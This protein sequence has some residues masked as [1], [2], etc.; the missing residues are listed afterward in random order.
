MKKALILIS[1]SFVLA[2]LIGGCGGGGGGGG[3]ETTPT[4]TPTGTTT[5]GGSPP[6]NEW[7]TIP[8]GDFIMGSG[9]AELPKHTVTLSEYKIQK[10]EVTNAQ[11]AACVAATACTAPA[12]ADS[13]T[14]PPSYTLTP[15]YGNATYNNYPVIFVNWTQ[16]GEYCAWVGGRLPTEAEWEKAARGPTPAEPIYPWGDGAADCTLANYYRGVSGCVGDTSEVGSHPTGVSYYGAMDMAGNVYEWVNDWYDATYYT[17]GGPPWTD[18]QGP[19]SGIYRVLRGG[20]WYNN[21]G[22]LRASYRYYHSGN[23]SFS[24]GFRCAQD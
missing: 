6:G 23:G 9:G 13:Y 11:Y 14:R 20:S 12:R 17:T 1:I 19:G 4:P 8:A 5:G 24:V 16:A 21:S 7:L 2:F 10:Y 18:P 22:Y 3:G 15:Y